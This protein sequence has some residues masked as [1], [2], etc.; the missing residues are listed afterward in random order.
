MFKIP[1][2]V[3]DITSP[4]MNQ[5]VRRRPTMMALLI[6]FAAVR[7]GSAVAD[8]T[9]EWQTGYSLAGV[10]GIVYCSITHDD[11]S[12]PKVYIGGQFSSA[13]GEWAMSVARWN[14]VKWEQVGNGGMFAQ[15]AGSGQA[16]VRAFAVYQ[17]HL[18]AGGQFQRAGNTMARNIA[19][20]DGAN[21]NALSNGVSGGSNEVFALAEH[22]GLLYVTGTFTTAGTLPANGAFSI[23]SWNGAAFA[24]LGTGLRTSA[25]QAGIGNGLRSFNNE[26]YATGSFASAGGVSNTGGIAKWTGAAWASVGTGG[27]AGT[28]RALTVFDDDGPGPNQPSLIVGGVF[29]S[30]AG[31]AAANVARYD[32]SQWSALGD[33]VSVGVNSIY[34]LGSLDAGD[35][36]K[37]YAGGLTLTET[38]GT[39]DTVKQWNGTSWEAI[40]GG[41]SAFG[42]VRGACY[43]LQ[44]A[45][46]DGA[47]PAS[48][49]LL[50]GGQFDSFG[51]TP[52]ANL[53]AFDGS[54]WT[55][56]SPGD[57]P[58]SNAGSNS[59]TG[60]I[61]GDEDGAG[62]LGTA[63]YAY[64]N[65]V[66]AGSTQARGGVA[67]RDGDSWTELT[68]LTG[69]AAAASV[70]AVFYDDGAGPRL[71][72]FG[73]SGS[74]IILSKW[75][76]G[77]WTT[78][79]SLDIGTLRSAIVW[80]SDGAGP[81][82]AEIYIGGNLGEYG[83]M[84]WNG[85][86]WSVVGGA[87]GTTYP[88]EFIFALAEYDGALY[89]GGT[90]RNP[91]ESLAGGVARWDG[92][93]WTRV[94]TSD[95]LVRAML[96]FQD[97]LYVGGEFTTMDAVNSPGLVKWDGT[98]WSD[99]GG[100]MT[101]AFPN[102]RSQVFSLGVADDGTGP[103]LFLGGQF[104]TAGGVADTRGV[105]KWNG[106]AFQ[107]L[108]TG[109]SVYNLSL[110]V[111]MIH[112]VTSIAGVGGS[113][114]LA[115]N[116]NRAGDVAAY[117][118]AEWRCPASAASPGDLNCDNVVNVSDIE[119]FV[120]AL[121]DPD[122]YAVEHP[123]C[124]ITL[125]DVNQDGNIDGLDI[126]P[127]AG[128]I[129]EP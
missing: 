98:A 33:G 105:A 75:D 80:D 29:T 30:V 15:A 62:P 91:D 56:V 17:G 7:P 111:P 82:P 50:V 65:F 89:A 13:G 4:V 6:A 85:A 10:N 94:G 99:V 18:Y 16:R 67:R 68:G 63:L 44:S 41:P 73:Q 122:A 1:G 121:I 23:A 93:A 119:A 58:W 124:Q 20:W 42:V 47:G 108:D 31:V 9:P 37:L 5:A 46:L 64:G 14:G 103:H 2:F 61:V 78:V 69:S 115:G 116:F 128:L 87:P 70:A 81:N 59:F 48:P 100:G 57:A 53:A 95:N 107:P 114:W 34:S 55:Q 118:I 113:V 106:T 117:R 102:A 126:A 28:G 45:D 77:A 123:I 129:V 127:F 49:V 26:L 109:V 84:K 74:T 104:E 25:N 27:M 86:A 54:A 112:N 38:G 32:G 101:G 110:T 60:L 39:P 3:R 72:V 8:C 96:V 76:G 79:S 66:T 92:T 35:G 36:T 120:L 40:P 24:A 71:H 19:Y 97:D 51:S 11:G 43:M 12:R 125:A 90:I 52:A 21:W 22:N 88:Y 83:V